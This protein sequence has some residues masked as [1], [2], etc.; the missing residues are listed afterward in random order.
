MN[1]GTMQCLLHNFPTNICNFAIAVNMHIYSSLVECSLS[2]GVSFIHLH[3]MLALATLLVQS[4]PRGLLQ[5][6]TSICRN[7]YM[8]TRCTH[9]HARARTCIRIHNGVQYL[10][11]EDMFTYYFNTD[12]QKILTISLHNCHNN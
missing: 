10:V 6:R 9:K 11:S 4:S 5:T 3:L 8:C 12:V 1:S 7:A 2:N